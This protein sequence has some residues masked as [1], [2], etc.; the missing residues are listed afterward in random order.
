MRMSQIL[1]ISAYSAALVVFTLALSVAGRFEVAAD[2]HHPPT[3][4]PAACQWRQSGTPGY[5]SCFAAA[6]A[7]DMTRTVTKDTQLK[8]EPISSSRDVFIL[9]SGA[10]VTMLDRTA[11]GFWCH[12]QSARASG[13]VP[14]EVL[15]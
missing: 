8:A 3:P 13:Y 11:N 15:N 10:T 9:N 14:F 5:Q 6:T 7:S 1:R 12:V 4:G 2:G